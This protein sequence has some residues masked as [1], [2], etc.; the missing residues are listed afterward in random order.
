MKKGLV[1]MLEMR[2]D[3]E[4]KNCE[5]DDY[6]SNIIWNY[7]TKVLVARHLLKKYGPERFLGED[8]AA[9]KDNEKF[10]DIPVEERRALYHFLKKKPH[11]T[12]K[13]LGKEMFRESEFYWGF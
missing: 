6:S 8:G 4:E 3:P 10:F 1:S 7:E 11:F 9:E 5:K 12:N 2:D 13:Q